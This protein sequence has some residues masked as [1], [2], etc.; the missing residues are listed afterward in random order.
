M[1]VPLKHVKHSMKTAEIRIRTTVFP[2]CFTTLDRYVI[3]SKHNTVEDDVFKQVPLQRSAA[4]NRP[5]TPVV[6]DPVAFS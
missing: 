3:Y 1:H 2:I 4:F 5:Q 6:V